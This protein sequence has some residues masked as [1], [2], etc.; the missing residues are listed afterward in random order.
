MSRADLADIS[1]LGLVSFECG[2]E[3]VLFCEATGALSLL[4]ATASLVW[5]ALGDGHTVIAICEMLAGATGAD[6]ALV[7]ADVSGLLDD[8]RKM[9]VPRLREPAGADDDV[10]RPYERQTITLPTFA[11]EDRYRVLDLA[12]TIRSQHPSDQAI[13]RSLFGHLPR[14][15]DVGATFDIVHTG[16]SLW[17]L[18]CNGCIVGNGTAAETLAPLLHAAVLDTAYTKTPCLAGIHAAVVAASGH[19]LLM[20]AESRSGKS[21]LTAALVAAGYTYCSDD[22]AVLTEPPIAIRP[23]PVGMGLKTGSWVPL[24]DR[25]AGLQTLPVH[26]RE[27]GQLIRYHVPAPDRIASPA[28]RYAT[29]AIVFPRYRPDSECSCES[30]RPGQALIR[31]TEAGYDLD[32]DT[33]VVAGLVEWLA[34]I[35]AYDLR[36]SALDEAVAAIGR[37]VR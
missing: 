30:I 10:E 18:V 21:T 6:P 2:P 16:E 17:T 5:R 19:A 8:W 1:E 28:A 22:L 29:Q 20:P 4:N 24:A 36:Y 33:A 35:P 32:L 27:D 13:A 15:T 11:F 31:L 34:D 3:V 26:R 25:L 23:V 9:S 37:I 14:S 12:F 7:A